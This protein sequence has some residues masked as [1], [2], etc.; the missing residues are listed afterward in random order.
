MRRL[1]QRELAGR[2]GGSQCRVRRVDTGSRRAD[3]AD[4]ENETARLLPIQVFSPYLAS[5]RV[6]LIVRR[7]QSRGS[8]ASLHHFSNSDSVSM[9]RFFRASLS[10][11][12]V[13]GTP[14]RAKAVLTPRLCCGRQSLGPFAFVPKR[15]TS[16]GSNRVTCPTSNV[17]QTLPGKLNSRHT[18]RSNFFSP[19]RFALREAR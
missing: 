1:S 9:F 17:A 12:I 18:S 16:V 13:G 6:P 3:E 2:I 10:C 11:S 7:R 4:S 5:R 14:A 19:T 8:L 15:G